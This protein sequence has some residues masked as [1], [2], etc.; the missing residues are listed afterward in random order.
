MDTKRQH[1]LTQEVAHDIKTGETAHR[2]SVLARHD[3]R[4]HT[5]Y[6]QPGDVSGGEFRL[7][8]LIS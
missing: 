2:T 7:Y 1:W 6:R 4:V 8:A 5:V 3:R